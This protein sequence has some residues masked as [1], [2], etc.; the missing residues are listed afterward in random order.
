MKRGTQIAYIPNHAHGDINHPDVEFGFVTS[1]RD[2]ISIHFCRFWRRGAEGKSLRT[3]SCSES[4][5]DVNLV[6]HE[7]VSQHIIENT[8]QELP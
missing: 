8:L 1:Q 6:K 7:Y 4:V 2:E 3:T 5:C